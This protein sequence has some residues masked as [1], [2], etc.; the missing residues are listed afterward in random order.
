MRLLFLLWYRIL[1]QALAL[2][3][4][5]CSSGSSDAD[6]AAATAQNEQHINQTDVTER[7]EADA[8]FMVR[9]SGNILLEVELGKLAQAQASTPAVRS[10]GTRLVQNRME[11]LQ[12]VRSLAAAKQLVIPAALSDD[13][14]AAYHEVSTTPRARLDK[15]LLAVAIKAQEQD[16]DA[17]D[18]MQ[19][20]AYDGDIR[21]L[22]AKYLPP[23]REQLAAAKE[24]EDELA[25]LP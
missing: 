22:A 11:L 25:D 13:E 9:L 1:P 16:E 17:L 5:A 2:L 6:S 12:A 18:D 23:V 10:Y 3:L 21:G 20:D 14:Q 19:D 15:K 4:L 7:Q 8:A 24:I